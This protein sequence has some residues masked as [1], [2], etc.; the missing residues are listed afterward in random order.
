VRKRN[1]W[2]LFSQYPGVKKKF[3]SPLVKILL[4][5]GTL[6]LPF[7]ILLLPYNINSLSLSE[8]KKIVIKKVFSL[9]LYNLDCAYYDYY[10]RREE[11]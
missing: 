4:Y 3:F 2:N 6:L 8:N 1:K 10:S 7:H 11:I 5:I 9:Y